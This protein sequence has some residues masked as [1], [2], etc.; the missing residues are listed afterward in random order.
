MYRIG[1]IRD[2][3][4][5]HFLTVGR[6]ETEKKLH[7]HCYTVEVELHGEVLGDQGYLLDLAELEA[8]VD[9]LVSRYRDTVLNELPEFSGLNPSIE[10]FARIL[11]RQVSAQLGG[12]KLS[13]VEVKVWEDQTAWASFRA[14]P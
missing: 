1:L 3:I 10:N 6:L 7:F 13:A 14:Q 5:R 8:L 12:R 4:A 9:S 2:F 11:G